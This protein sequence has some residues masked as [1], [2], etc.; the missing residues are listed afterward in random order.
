MKLNPS[1]LDSLHLDAANSLLTAR[2]LQLV[3]SIFE[4][5]DVHNRRALNGIPCLYKS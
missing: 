4:N 5:L 2:D 3:I 1:V